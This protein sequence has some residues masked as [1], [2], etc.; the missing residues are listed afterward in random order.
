ML[1]PVT[2]DRIGGLPAGEYGAL[3]C[4][5]VPD[6]ETIRNRFLPSYASGSKP[7]AKMAKLILSEFVER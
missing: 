1:E 2:A 4:Q 3:P 6:G 5:R 7:A